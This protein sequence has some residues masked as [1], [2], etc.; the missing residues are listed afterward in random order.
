MLNASPDLVVLRGGVSVM[1]PAMRL[2]LDLEDRGFTFAVDNGELV[3]RPRALLTD[4]DR[5][6][7]RRWV[8]D[9]KRIASYSVTV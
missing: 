9:L 8:D 7:I 2:A 1:L 3:V 5:E 4:R 6:H